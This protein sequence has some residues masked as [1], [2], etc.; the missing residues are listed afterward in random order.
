MLMETL[1]RKRFFNHP[2][3]F[4]HGGDYNPEQWLDRPDILDED[5]RLMKR[6]HVNTVTLGVFS[7][8]VYEPVEG[9]YHF[10]WLTGLMDRL[11]ENGI[12]T[13][14]STP[15]GAKPAWLDEKYPSALR[16]AENGLRIHHGFRENHCMTSPEY[17]EK[18]REID[19]RLAETVKG[20]PGLILWHISNEFNGECYCDLCKKKFQSYLSRKFDGQIDR[21]N[22]EW[23]TCFWSHR[24]NSFSQVEPPYAD[25]ER[26]VMGLNLEWRRFT[27]WNTTDF[28][29]AE[30]ETIREIT[31]GI[32]FTTNFMRLYPGLDYHMMARELDLVSWDCYPDWN[33]DRESMI[34]T[35]RQVAFDHALMRSMKPDQPFLLMESVPSQ[36]NWHPVN[37]L[38]RPGLHKLSSLQAVACGSDSVQY[39]QWRKGRGS[40]EQYHGAVIGHLGTS[41]TRVFREVEDTGHFLEEISCAAG[42]VMRPRAAVLFDWSCWWAIDDLK[43][44]SENR[45]YPDTVWE[46]YVTL[47]KMGVEADVISPYEDLSR[48]AFVVAPML[49]IVDE[50]IASNLKKFVSG[51]GTLLATYLC[52]YVNE[53]T[54]CYLG[55]FPGAGLREVFG[56]YAE[57]IDNLYPSERNGMR[58]CDAEGEAVYPVRDYCELLKPETA[59]TLGVYTTDFYAG[60]PLFTVHSYGQ[61]RAYYVGAR[62]EADGMDA[63]YR[64][65]L[66]RLTDGMSDAESAGLRPAAALPNGLEHHVRTDGKTAYHFYLN[67]TDQDITLQGDIVVPAMDVKV[68]ED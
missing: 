10:E 61:G 67:Y 44:L 63:V 14:L 27:S 46:Q 25:G 49:Y 42:S 30:I 24:Y 60:E 26:S 43:G 22:H 39:F 65:V 48:Y 28:M 58:L 35:A 29:K 47:L 36:V 20:H 64:L 41:D 23:W 12:Y 17:R 55:G 7:W 6:A 2:D 21:L 1:I 3:G 15:S 13:V 33:N 31:P 5:I 45:C 38:K 11:Y 16:V 68:L 57:E 53:N 37:K 34:D 66:E 52:G 4:L 50:E 32:P 56:L 18:V 19:R 51:G 40:F 8:S 59:E 9:E 62:L 54:L